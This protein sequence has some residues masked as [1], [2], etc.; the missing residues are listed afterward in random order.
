MRFAG[1]DRIG[2]AN[3]E[4]TV[5]FRRW[6]RPR[7]VAGRVYRT[8]GGRLLVDAV[9]RIAPSKVTDRDARAAGRANA[10]AVRDDDRGDTANPL[11]RVRFHLV[12]DP[13]DRELLAADDDLGPDDLAE[14][15]RASCRERV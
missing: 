13:D 10:A 15:G 8:N 1:R 12:T 14:I 7:V 3:G 9:D 2:V 4:I 11:Y 5:A 6:E